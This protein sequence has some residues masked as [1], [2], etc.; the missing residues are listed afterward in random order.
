MSDWTDT[1]GWGGWG[2]PTNSRKAHYFEAGSTFSLCGRY[3]FYRGPREP[4]NGES[5]DDCKECRKKLDRPD[6]KAS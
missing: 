2:F 3:G 6:G 4:D 1:A 5:V